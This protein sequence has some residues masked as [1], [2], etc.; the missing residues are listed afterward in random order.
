MKSVPL[1][2]RSALCATGWQAQGSPHSKCKLSREG[3]LG[4]IS[5]SGYASAF[6]FQCAVKRCSIDTDLIGDVGE[7]VLA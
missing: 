3:Q 4:Q 2:D 1:A 7:F 5:Y 6:S